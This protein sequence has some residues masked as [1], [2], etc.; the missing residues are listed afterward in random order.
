MEVFT[1]VF[2]YW[3]VIAKYL[4]LGIQIPRISRHGC[5][6]RHCVHG[7]L[8]C[9]NLFHGR[10]IVVICVNNIHGRLYMIH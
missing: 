1:S 2:E 9:F 6:A 3:L 10:C 8:L 5:R 7:L 4:K